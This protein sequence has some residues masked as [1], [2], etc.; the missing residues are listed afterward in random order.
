MNAT[1]FQRIYRRNAWHG[2]DTRSGPGSSFAA[3]AHLARWL[4]D[5]LWRSDLDDVSTVLDVPCGE[6]RW[7]PTLDGFHYVGVDVVP[8]AV[9]AAR[10]YHPDRP[11]F[12]ANAISDRLPDCDL[13]FT[14]D[15]MQHLS[16]VDGLSFIKN[17]Q[18]SQPQFIVASTYVDGDNV[19]SQSA[20]HAYRVN[21]Q[22]EPFNFGDPL[23]L[24]PDGYSEN[25]TLVDG[26]KKLGVWQ[27]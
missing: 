5:L 12:T 8:E 17:V 10:R 25:G 2:R 7:F 21:L 18:R 9:V 11:F 3:T 20:Y 27:L 24:V 26:G 19:G 14:R 1:D 13:A 15:F 23:D 16:V 6:G 22:A 4:T